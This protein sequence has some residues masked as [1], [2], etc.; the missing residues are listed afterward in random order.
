MRP[1]RLKKFDYLGH[2]RYSLTIVC[3]QRRT[4][5]VERA[6]AET[7]VQQIWQSA[8]RFAFAIL[9]YCIMPDHLHLLVQ[10]N[11]ENSHLP[12]YV[13]HFKQQAAQKTRKYC[14]R[15]WQPGYFDRADR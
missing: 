6:I 4:L 9:A 11:A 15:L 8:E 3:F 2:H 10:G 12:T 14:D 5:F 7:V 13:A 1:P